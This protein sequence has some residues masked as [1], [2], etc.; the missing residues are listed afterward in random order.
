MDVAQEAGGWLETLS[1]FNEQYAQTMDWYPTR[2]MVILIDFD[3]DEGRGNWAKAQIPAH[4]TNRVFVLG[5]LSQPEALRRAGLGSYEQIG[6]AMAKD[7]HDQTAEI[8]G[9]E[10][11]RHNTEELDRLR[12]RVRPFLFRQAT[13]YE[14]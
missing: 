13:I 5:V 4:L 8:W 9:H 12:E 11:L 10:L 6:L 7:C 1:R 14:Q 2:Y 3:D